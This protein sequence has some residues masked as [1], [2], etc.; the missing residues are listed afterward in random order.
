MHYAILIY[1]DAKVYTEMSK[2]EVDA[3]MVNND[4]FIE[5]YKD[6][7]TNAAALQGVDQ[8]TTVRV[9]DGKTLTSDGPFAETKEQ[10][11]GIC[12]VECDNLDEAL[13][14]AARI[15]DAAHGSIEVRP[16]WGHHEG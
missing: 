5:Q 11:G 6:R 10:L 13:E 12:Q 8:A 16:I 4:A 3:L 1:V 14:M 9:R 15:P 2:E 7:I